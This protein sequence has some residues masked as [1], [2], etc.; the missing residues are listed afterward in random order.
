MAFGS[1]GFTSP[2]PK[3]KSGPAYAGAGFDQE[4]ER[5]RTGKAPASGGD[6][7]GGQVLGS[8][9]TRIGGGSNPISQFFGGGPGVTVGQAG[10]SA[11]TGGSPAPAT[12]PAIN[13]N[14]LIKQNIEANPYQV[15]AYE[16]FEDIFNRAPDY[17][18][19]TAIGRDAMAGAM[20]EAQAMAGMRGAL[21]GT[22]AQAM[23]MG[24][25]AQQGQRDLWG[26]LRDERQ[27]IFENQLN[28]TRGMGQVGGDIAGNLLGQQG[29]YIDAYNALSNY[30]LG[31]EKN[32]IDWYDSQNSAAT[33]MMNAMATLAR[34]AYI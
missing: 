3:K 6:P 5:G 31:N 20:K 10:G 34:L 27:R 16:H 7:T 30:A 24:D 25:I 9:H 21:P 4:A 1:I 17:D 12:T 19:V 22:G 26:G 15:G 11:S 2:Q 29:M 8:S 32:Q 28:A 18:R 23:M 14:D 33:G 13:P